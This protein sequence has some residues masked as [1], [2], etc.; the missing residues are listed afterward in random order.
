MVAGGLC[1]CAG[2]AH[3]P[4]NEASRHSVG[5]VSAGHHLVQVGPGPG[6]TTSSSQEETASLRAITSP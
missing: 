2:L 4:G 3:I 1:R 5:Q 6:S